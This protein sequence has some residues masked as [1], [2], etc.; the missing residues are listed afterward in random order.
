MTDR[1]TQIAQDLENVTDPKDHSIIKADAS[2][3]KIDAEVKEA[4]AKHCADKVANKLERD[5]YP[6]AADYVRQTAAGDGVFHSDLMDDPF[7]SMLL[8]GL[9][10]DEDDR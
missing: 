10:D 9:V 4:I 6:D 2:W 7:L 8:D 5:G 3:D 1:A